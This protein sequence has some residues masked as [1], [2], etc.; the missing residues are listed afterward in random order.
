MADQSLKHTIQKQKA[1]A[2][3]RNKIKT[4]KHNADNK[5]ASN[6]RPP[7]FAFAIS[8]FSNFFGCVTARQPRH[9]DFSVE[10]KGKRETRQKRELNCLRGRKGDVKGRMSEE[11]RKESLG[12]HR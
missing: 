9:F 3:N 6:P 1:K 11:G 12:P 10:G 8:T 5:W 7:F 2:K 4:K